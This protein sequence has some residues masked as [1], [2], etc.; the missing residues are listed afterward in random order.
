MGGPGTHPHLQRSPAAMIR[1]LSRGSRR[2]KEIGGR[3]IADKEEFGLK[4]AKAR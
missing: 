1:K 2:A 3:S 4:E